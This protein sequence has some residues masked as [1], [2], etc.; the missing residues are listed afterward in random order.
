MQSNNSQSN[1]AAKFDLIKDISS[2]VG[3]DNLGN[4]KNAYY[5]P[6]NNMALIIAY[7]IFKDVEHENNK[8]ILKS[9]GIDPVLVDNNM[10]EAIKALPQQSRANFESLYNFQTFCNPKLAKLLSDFPIY[11][12]QADQSHGWDNMDMQE[13]CQHAI[14]NST[15]TL[16]LGSL[17]MN[18]TAPDYK[19]LNITN[20]NEHKFKD[21]VK[22]FLTNTEILISKF[23]LVSSPSVFETGLADNTKYRFKDGEYSVQD[24]LTAIVTELSNNLKKPEYAIARDVLIAQI[25]QVE[26]DLQKRYPAQYNIS[27][28][29]TFE[30]PPKSSKN[31]WIEKTSQ[32]MKDL[33]LGK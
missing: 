26:M 23:P 14:Q 15:D 11:K 32:K 2:A 6:Q 12:L 24:F 20:L 16:M 31:T 27:K 30:L 10:E 9:R 18:S 33:C 1:L 8:I 21:I 25:D 22:Y 17:D 5:S 13:K 19:S 3:K 28:N 7:K 4:T 29:L